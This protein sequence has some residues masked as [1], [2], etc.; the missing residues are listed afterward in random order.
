MKKYRLLSLVALAA[1]A[2]PM[3]QHAAQAAEA[4]PKAYFTN[5]KNG[6]MVSNPVKVTFGLSGMK[7]APAGTSEP[8]TGHFHLL[9]DTKLTK[10]EMQYAIPKDDQHQQPGL[11]RYRISDGRPAKRGWHRA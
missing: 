9:I 2:L 4:P 7:V 3:L 5:L 1:L 6:D 10:E 8:N 11:G